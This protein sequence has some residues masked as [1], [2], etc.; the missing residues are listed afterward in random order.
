ML[1]KTP[2]PAV[3]PRQSR[4]R[5]TSTLFIRR[6]QA[7]RAAD[8]IRARVIEPPTAA[9]A[10][11]FGTSEHLIRREL[12]AK[13]AIDAV[14]AAMTAADRDRFVVEHLH[15]LWD[16]IDRATAKAEVELTA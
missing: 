12:E 10:R 1:M 16:R 7:S 2:E 11:R 15:D 14:W 6:S 5:P 13:P 3:L 9:A 8:W 4:S